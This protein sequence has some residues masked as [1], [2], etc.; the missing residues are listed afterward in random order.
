[1]AAIRLPFVTVLFLCVFNSVLAQSLYRETVINLEPERFNYTLSNSPLIHH[2]ESVWADSLLLVN[3]IDYRMI[4]STGEL[5]LITEPDVPMLKVEFLLVPEFLNKPL[6]RYETLA[7]SDSLFRSIKR[8]NNPIFV[9][10][11]RLDVQ[12]S[13][14]FAITFSDDQAFDLKQSLFVN[15]SGELAKDVSISAQL[16][17]SQSKLSPEGDSKELSSLDNVFIKIYGNHYELAMGD[18]ELKYSGT[19]YL[20][21]SS[22]FEGVNA[23]YN[24]KHLI[25][26]A[27]SA[28]S[29]KSASVSL[30]IVD[31]KQGPYY[32][33]PNDY[34][35]SFIVVAGSE[36]IFVDGDLWE[37]GVGYSIDYAEG[38]VMFKRLIS[39]TNRV[40]V[41]F[42][43]SDEYYPSSS[44]LNSSLLQVTDNLSLKH[45][46]IW[47]QD[48][49]KNPLLYQF[50]QADKD[51]LRLAGDQQV[52][53]QGVNLVVSGTG[54]YKQM[55]SSTGIVYYEYAPGDSLAS[56]NVIFSYMGYGF[57]DYLE[58]S[59]GK[60]RY[61]GLNLGSWLPQKR[62][63]A[64]SKHGNLDL[65]LTFDS[66]SFKAGL[67]TLGTLNDRNTMSNRDDSDN[68]GGIAY[69]FAEL[70]LETNIIR[71][72]HEQRSADTYLFGKYRDPNA[73]LDFNSIAKADSLAQQESN[74]L[75]SHN[76]VGWKA[77]LLLRYKDIYSLYRQNALRFSTSVPSKK[78][79]PALNLRSTFSQ[80]DYHKD[81]SQ[82]AAMQYHQS[83]ISWLWKSMRLRLEGLYNI[84]ESKTTGNSYKKITPLIS[85]GK[86]SSVWTQLSYSDDAIKVKNN[87]LWISGNK[88]QTY[89]LK[90]ILN[91][92]TQRLDFDWTHRELQS[93]LSTTNPKSSYDLINLRSNHAFLKQA[94]V[95]YTNYQL[96]QTEFFPKIRELQYLGNGLG[97]YDS[98]GVSIPNGDYDYVFITSSS[99]TLS[100][101]TN[102]IITMYLKPGN[103]INREPLKRLQLDSTLNLNEQSSA[104]DDWRSYLF[105]PGTV[106]NEH[107]TIFGRQNL[108]QTL[109]LELIKNHITGNLQLNYDRN[110]DKRYQSTDRANSFS[111]QMQM[112]IKGYSAYNIRL[113]YGIDNT[114]DS[115]YASQTEVQNFSAL[116]QRNL[117]V[118]TSLQAEL[119]LASESGSKQDSSESYR[120]RSVQLSPT[121][122][123]VWMQK[124]RMSAGLSITRNMLSGSNYF[125]FLPNKR[126]GWIPA[127]S[128]NGLYRINSY[129]SI[130]LDY[131]FSDY[132]SQSSTHELK[133][134]FK[135][136]L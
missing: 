11:A 38:S 45:H 79:L 2:S 77:S 3:G 62:L 26:T 30:S 87:S 109:W 44:L 103:Y 54:E 123:S 99:G 41:R 10:D 57:G 95:L 78:L 53:G 102:A 90:Q 15:I 81:D 49:G 97:L 70:P 58:F 66:N 117:A 114:E 67:E 125:G 48:D 124:Y 127:I 110:L 94:F 86:T 74:L 42:H 107:R 120:L 23:W 132:P 84:V 101:E 116:V 115:R 14:T 104:Q 85:I 76:G 43:Y 136:E 83:D 33:S 92:S 59:S 119:I 61:I 32:L 31:G 50:T 18:L 17:D 75:L 28:S 21:Y 60:F 133:L 4:Y 55:L 47:Q 27:Y 46:F 98:T 118:Q 80:Q 13:K 93:P 69:A 72:D 96:N 8:K 24:N 128:L 39:S 40:L 6:Q 20:E 1:L 129:S 19:R 71:L 134:E 65:A 126:E 131:R 22:K 135:A 88:S 122:K 12:G 105:W 51:S 91:S 106:F 130:S 52:W 29:G 112:D 37:R 73:E 89:A 9:S 35:P 56:Y 121:I 64:P 111:R 113:Q 5:I 16:S 82:N 63:I 108:Q 68:V 25:Q 7:R 34:Q 36:E 100:T